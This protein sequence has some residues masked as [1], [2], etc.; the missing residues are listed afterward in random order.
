MTAVRSQIVAAA[1]EWIGTPYVH[2]ASLLGV[3]CDCLGLVRGVFRQ[4][5]GAEPEDVPPYSPDWSEA[6][7]DERLWRAARRH[8]LEVERG[9][10]RPGDMILMRM[11]EGMVAK[12]VGIAA[13][14]VAG[15]TLIH[16]YSRRGVVESPMTQSWSRLTVAAFA[17]PGSND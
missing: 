12:H 17:F 2:Q 1:R 5:F 10:V 16:A 13:E 8:L 3:G 14:G 7:G 6:S 9:C 11:R 4:L 15:P